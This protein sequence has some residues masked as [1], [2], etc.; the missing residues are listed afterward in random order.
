[1]ASYLAEVGRILALDVGGK[2]IGLAISDPSGVLATPYETV[3][4]RGLETDISA[5]LTVVKEEVVQRLIVGLPISMNGVIGQQAK[6]TLVFCE[7][8]RKKSPVLVETWNEQLSTF[9][10]ETRLREANFQP[11]RNKKMLDA[12]AAAVILQSYLDA[13]R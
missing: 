5:I 8:L 2:R 11:S 7:A 6:E 9:E 1:M 3:T 4:R 12:S 10:A 13:I